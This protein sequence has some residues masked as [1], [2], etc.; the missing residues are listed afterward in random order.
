MGTIDFDK[1]AGP[2]ERKAEVKVGAKFK[3]EDIH[4][5]IVKDV[6]EGLS[7]NTKLVADGKPTKYVTQE[8]GSVEAA[9]EWLKQ[10]TKYALYR[11]S[12]QITVRVSN[13]QAI[14]D[15]KATSVEY[16]AKPLE[17]RT[18]KG[19]QEGKTSK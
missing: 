8:C 13:R 10:M 14:K 19:G 17:I 11:P 2:V 16:A 4:P 15:G 6:E 18:A 1:L 3:I 7:V 5:R 12:G 9:Q